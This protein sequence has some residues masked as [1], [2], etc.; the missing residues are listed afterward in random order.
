MAKK[1]SATVS[2]T[3]PTFGISFIIGL[4]IALVIIVGVKSGFL[5]KKSLTNSSLAAALLTKEDIETVAKMEGRLLPELV[6]INDHFDAE[7]AEKSGYSTFVARVISDKSTNDGFAENAILGFD[8]TDVAKKFLESRAAE[9]NVAV[10]HDIDETTPTVKIVQDKTADKSSSVTF[11][12]AVKQLAARVQVYGEAAEPIALELARKQKEKLD[13]LL[14]GSL[15]AVS[16]NNSM[17]KLPSTLENATLVGKLPITADE[18]MGATHDSNIPGLQSGGLARFKINARP[19]EALEV[20]V[21][22]FN[23]PQDALN[24]K[25]TFFTQ[26]AHLEDKSSKELAL[27]ASIN[28]FSL[29]RTSDA[30]DELA[31]VKGNYYIDISTFSPFK[32]FDKDTSSPDLVKISEE[33]LSKF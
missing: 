27:P 33:I 28:G 20:V 14:A 9:A 11:R 21:L 25:N 32:D 18:W 31:A 2:Y 16:E 1:K 10:G 13:M 24:Y 5:A 23:S 19:A 22:E 3:S 30:I 12:I 15:P 4:V 7:D 26:G 6:Q 8:S 29:A 17:S